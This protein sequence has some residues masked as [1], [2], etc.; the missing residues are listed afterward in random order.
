M[1][2]GLRFLAP[3]VDPRPGT[4]PIVLSRLCR[5]HV[6]LPGSYIVSGVGV[7]D[8]KGTPVPFYILLPPPSTVWLSRLYVY[9]KTDVAL[10]SH[11]IYLM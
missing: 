11:L 3:A 2:S 5:D 10:S 1:I 9:D 8:E 4:C 6:I 7:Q